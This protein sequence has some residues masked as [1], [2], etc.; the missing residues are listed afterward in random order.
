[1]ALS[2]ELVQTTK[3]LRHAPCLRGAAPR[4]VG[5][6]GVEDLADRADAGVGEE[7]SEALDEAESA[8]IVAGVHF[9]PGVE[10]RSDE[11]GPD[12]TLMIGGVACAKIAVICRLLGRMIG[13]E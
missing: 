3:N 5:R 9:Q 6:F 12:R 4:V 10:E 1:M 11:P 13:R 8:C 7:R 2:A